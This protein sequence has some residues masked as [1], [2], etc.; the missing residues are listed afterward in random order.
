MSALEALKLIAPTVHLSAEQGTVSAEQGSV[1]R[2]RGLTTG[3]ANSARDV[4][5]SFLPGGNR[6]EDKGTRAPFAGGRGTY[7]KV[8]K[9]ELGTLR[10]FYLFIIHT[11]SPRIKRPL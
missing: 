10:S 3:L 7:K 2:G 11:T 9:P 5:A 4:S 6:V 1:A 8:S